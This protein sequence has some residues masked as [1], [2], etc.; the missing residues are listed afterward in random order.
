MKYVRPGENFVAW[1]K[2]KHGAKMVDG[3]AIG[4]WTPL[5]VSEREKSPRGSKL[6]LFAARSLQH[7]AARRASRADRR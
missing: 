6:E 2:Q 3:E 5:A 7:L 4:E 1:L